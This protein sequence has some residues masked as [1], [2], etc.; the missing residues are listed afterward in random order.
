MKDTKVVK[1]TKSLINQYTD[2]K[3]DIK[4]E[5]GLS[6]NSTLSKLKKFQLSKI[7]KYLGVNLAE[8]AYISD[9]DAIKLATIVKIP[10]DYG[11]KIG[12]GATFKITKIGKKT[13]G[14]LLIYLKRLIDEAKQKEKNQCDRANDLRKD[15]SNLML[16]KAKIA[17]CQICEGTGKVYDINDELTTCWNCDGDKKVIA[18]KTI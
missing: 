12:I 9:A 15:I 14:R 13:I 5:L 7:T 8:V 1:D 11:C 3:L 10:Q 17:V 4:A 16:G 2:R 6:V 18:E